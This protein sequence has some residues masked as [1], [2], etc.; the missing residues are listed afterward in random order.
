M[1]WGPGA[2]GS[3]RLLR[4]E[5][6]VTKP[7]AGTAHCL[8]TAFTASFV[9]SFISVFSRPCVAVWIFAGKNFR[10]YPALPGVEM[11]GCWGGRGA[12]RAVKRTAVLEPLLCLPSHLFLPPS[13]V[14]FP[15]SDDKRWL[16]ISDEPSLSFLSHAEEP[17]RRGHLLPE[18][19]AKPPAGTLQPDPGKARELPCRLC[20][21]I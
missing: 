18:G 6:V 9:S 21:S 20:A 2:G 3:D 12:P 13:P 8:R 5:A 17:L 7:G 19:V 15:L 10:H 16:L 11:P 14:P 4:E 1:P